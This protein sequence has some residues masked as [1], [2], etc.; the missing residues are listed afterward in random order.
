MIGVWAGL[1]SNKPNELVSTAGANLTFT[2][3]S[4]GLDQDVPND[5]AERPVLPLARPICTARFPPA[6]INNSLVQR[7]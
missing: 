2:T 3:V 4:L 5:D 1:E 7:S 6:A